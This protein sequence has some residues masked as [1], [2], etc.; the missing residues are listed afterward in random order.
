MPTDD[1]QTDGIDW[2]LTTWE[3]A[4]RGQMRRWGQMPLAGERIRR[5]MA[6]MPLATCYHT[7]YKIASCKVASAADSLRGRVFDSD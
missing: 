5:V 6:T 2:S 4:R 7:S 1:S 3:G